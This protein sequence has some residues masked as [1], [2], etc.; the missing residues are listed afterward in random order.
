[1][2]GLG[3]GLCRQ[4]EGAEAREILAEGGSMG[5]R[6]CVRELELVIVHV[7]AEAREPGHDDGEMACEVGLVE[8]PC[9][10]MTDDDVGPA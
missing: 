8:R 4:D 7:L 6:Q 10:A 1:M 3:A 9:A 2:E 5:C